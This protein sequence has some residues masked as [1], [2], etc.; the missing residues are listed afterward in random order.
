MFRIA[1]QSLLHERGRLFASLAGVTF[2]TVLVVSQL[3]MYQGFLDSASAIITRMGGDAWVMAKN[4]RVFDLA[5]PLSA[6]ARSIAATHPCVRRVRGVVTAFAFLRTPS[7]VHEGVEVIGFEPV[8]DVVFPWTFAAGLPADLHGAG[9]I[10]VDTLDLARLEIP[11]RPLGAEVDLGENHAWIAAVTGG[12]RGFTLQPYVFT[13]LDVAR[14]YTG[15]AEEQVH[16]LVLDWAT[17]A[18]GCVAS[19]R[20]AV[21]KQG[22][23]QLLE[24][25][26]FARMTEAYWVGGA[27]AGAALALGAIL[28][29]VVGVVIV[30]QTLYSLANDHR[31]ELATLK[32]LGGSAGEILQFVAWQAA[33]LAVFGGA[34]GLA[35]A[36]LIAQ[37]ALHVGL[38]IAL[39]PQ[40]LLVS[41]GAV[42]LMCALAS[43]WSVRAVLLLEA[44]EVFR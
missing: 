26:E 36:W 1:L 13:E 32:A 9:R 11:A 12:I 20:A 6:G 19:V 38:T 3:G 5:E 21:A 15:L 35:G 2:A 44:A 25:S 24:T 23:L 33:A 29:L 34:I 4:T 42:T 17:P 39:T 37:A 22:D 43:L 30:G 16:Y 41:L 18:R 7:G 27:G 8:P 28:G 14:Q 10:S 31:R 40:T